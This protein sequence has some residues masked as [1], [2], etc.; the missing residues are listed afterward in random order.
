M[1]YDH[2]PRRPGLAPGS[3]RRA[4]S[5]RQWRRCFLLRPT[6]GAIGPGARAG[7]T[8]HISSSQVVRNK[9][10]L[11]LR[12]A[13]SALPPLANDQRFAESLEQGPIDRIALRIV[14]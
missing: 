8:L 13:A 7:T 10:R 6:P 14:F 2:D 9:P 11:G 3:I 12:V 4:F 1:N 5:F